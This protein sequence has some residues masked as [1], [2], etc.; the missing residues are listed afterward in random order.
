VQLKTCVVVYLLTKRY[1]SLSSI[2]PQHGSETAGID[3]EEE[4]DVTDMICR[5]YRMDIDSGLRP[6]NVGRRDTW[7]NTSGRHDFGCLA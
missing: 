7:T 5:P 4:I 1:Q 3:M 6:T 2:A